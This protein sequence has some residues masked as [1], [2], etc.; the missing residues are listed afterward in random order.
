MKKSA[1]MLVL[2]AAI[3]LSAC[4]STGSKDT[5]MPSKSVITDFT[6]DGI[7]ITYTTSG[8]LEKIE[9]AGQAF[10]NRG[11]FQTLAEA[12]AK[13][14]LVKF[15][16]GEQVNSNKYV[17]I[18]TKSI[19]KAQEKAKDYRSGA[20][21]TSDKEF[22]DGADSGAGPDEDNVN[23]QMALR[24]NATITNNVTTIVSGGRLTGV[25]KVRDEFRK[26]GAI[27]VAVFVWSDKDQDSSEY[28]RS[29]M[30]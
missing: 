27:Y 19:E 25:R 16:H 24:L 20:V 23:R 6:D 29:R 1:I 2:V 18:L 9:V 11:D 17:R 5:P 7:Q 3:G 22:E 13:A 4:S 15:V 28:V 14:K 26:D 21:N 30:R 12:N 8:K 10:T